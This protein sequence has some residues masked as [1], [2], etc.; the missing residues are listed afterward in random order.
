MNV[1][2]W[3]TKK[4]PIEDDRDILARVGFRFIWCTGPYFLV[5]GILSFFGSSKIYAPWPALFFIA[6]RSWAELPTGIDSSIAPTCRKQ[7]IRRSRL[8][9]PIR[10]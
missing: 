3:L 4:L 7:H 1:W 6:S 8:T 2:Q 9:C 10:M 5:A